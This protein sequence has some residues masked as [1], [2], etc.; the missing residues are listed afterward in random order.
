[1]SET[2]LRIFISVSQVNKGPGHREHGQVKA[3]STLPRYFQMPIRLEKMTRMR[4]GMKSN[5]SRTI[6]KGKLS[7]KKSLVSIRNAGEDQRF[8]RHG[9]PSRHPIPPKKSPRNLGR[10]KEQRI[11]SKVASWSSAN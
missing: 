4:S 6:L 10:V 3:Y 2:Y 5:P 8:A 11:D 9:K 7:R 1:M